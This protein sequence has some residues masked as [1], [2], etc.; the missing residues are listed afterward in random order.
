MSF[1]KPSVCLLSTQD[2]MGAGGFK[3]CE[4]LHKALLR[5]DFSARMRVARKRSDS[6]M[7][8]GPSKIQSLVNLAKPI[9]GSLAIQLQRSSNKIIRSPAAVPS[10]LVN[11]LNSSNIDLLNLHWVCGEFLSVEEIGR[12]RKPIVWTLHDMWPFSGAEHYGDDAPNAR[13]RVGYNSRNRLPGDRGIDIDRWVWNR[14]CRSW[15]TPM[16]IVTPTEWLANCARQSVLMQNWPISVIPNPLDTECFRPWPKSMAR[17]MLGLPQ[18]KKLVLFGAIKGGSDPRKGWDLLQPTLAKLATQI[19]DLV[20]VVFGQSEPLN[21]PLL[22][23]PL[24]WMGH[25]YDDITLALL[26]SAADVTVV[27]SR[28]DNLPQTGTEAQACGCPVVAFNTCGLPSVLVHQETGYLA[29]PFD[30]EDLAQ[31]IAW[32][33]EDPHRYSLLSQQSR[34]R[35]VQ[36]WSPDV[37]IEQ[38]LK[39]YH[40]AIHHCA[41]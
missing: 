9:L 31:G 11:Q 30:I 16:H 25:I 28:Q 24:H 1:A 41:H 15:K 3:A 21:P 29:T 39:T 19:P 17:Q 8:D 13:W 18:D 20:G 6:S 23:L 22:G 26:Y 40:Q 10:G 37:I 36:I 2:M 4:R 32:V 12:L 33:L 34:S 38:Y 35:A 5:S 7:I 27:P 14:K